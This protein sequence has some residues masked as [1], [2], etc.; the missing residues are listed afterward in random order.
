[1]E[2]NRG[3]SKLLKCRIHTRITKDK[4]DE[5]NKLL[6][7]SRS[8]HSLSELLR[9]ILDNRKIIVHSYDASFD[10]VMAELSAIR[11]E[12]HAIGVNIN[13]VTHKFHMEDLPEGRLFQALELVKLYQQTDLKVSELFSVI[14]K[15]SEKWLPRS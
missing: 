9:H 8:I 3:E 7:Q 10:K 1:M 5:L 4:Y 2:R 11:T 6:Q 15:L 13:Q 12:L 14:A